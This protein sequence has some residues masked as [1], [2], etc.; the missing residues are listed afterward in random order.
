M[1]PAPVPIWH[2]AQY[3]AEDAR[4]FAL[5]FDAVRQSQGADRAE[6]AK[7]IAAMGRALA[8]EAEAMAQ[9]MDTAAAM[10]HAPAEARAVRK[11]YKD[12]D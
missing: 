10:Q 8:L 3:F 1:R 4:D 5:L 11:P 9:I 7:R 6:R 2:R 12:D